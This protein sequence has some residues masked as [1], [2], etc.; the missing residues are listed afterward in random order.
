MF[1]WKYAVLISRK[2]GS[3]KAILPRAVGALER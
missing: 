2:G 3:V 1:G